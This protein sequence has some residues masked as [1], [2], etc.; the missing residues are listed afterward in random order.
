[1]PFNMA[2]QGLN[3]LDIQTA[4]FQ[5]LS[6]L[7]PDLVY[8]SQHLLVDSFHLGEAQQDKVIMSSSSPEQDACTMYMHRGGTTCVHRVFKVG[9]ISANFFDHSIGRILV[10]LLVHLNKRVVQHGE[11]KYALEIYAITVDRR[12][13]FDTQ[14]F[15]NGTLLNYHDYDASTTREDTITR[16]LRE[17]LQQ[18]YIR[19]P[20]NVHTARSVLDAVKLDMLIFS[21][22]GMDFSTY[23][24]AFSRFAAVQVYFD[25]YALRY[26]L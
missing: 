20:D 1:M 21:D 5:V 3:D 24:L 9:F 8:T 2:H 25:Y 15:Y 26:V 11:G 7:C 23:Q 14:V 6:T 16:I 22:V 19:I 4:I 17:H 10:E 18:N 12:I 13:P